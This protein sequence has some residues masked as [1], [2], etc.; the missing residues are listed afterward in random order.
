MIP[1]YEEKRNFPRMTLNC[2][3]AVT[4]PEAGQTFKTMVINLSGGGALFNA[5]HEFRVGALLD[6]RVDSATGDRPPFEARIKV[7]RCEP[8]DKGGF[9]IASVIEQVQGSGA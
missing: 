4:D 5:E 2:E 1:D 6:L 3:A 7:I 8:R 9:Q